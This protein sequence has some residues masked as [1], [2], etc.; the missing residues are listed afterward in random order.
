MDIKRFKE[1]IGEIQTKAQREH[2][3]Q[4]AF[5]K[6]NEEWKGLG[7]ELVRPKDRDDYWILSGPNIEEVREL[8][9]DTMVRIS[10]IQNAKYVDQ[11]KD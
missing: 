2:E 7:I 10:N 1:D 6:V 9:E 3:L 5:E 8:L 11:I 4:E